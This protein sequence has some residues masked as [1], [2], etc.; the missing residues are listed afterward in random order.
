MGESPYQRSC[1]SLISPLSGRLL[2]ALVIVLNQQL[3]TE[4]HITPAASRAKRSWT[5]RRRFVVAFT[6]AATPFGVSGCQAVFSAWGLI[7]FNP[8][9]SAGVYQT[10]AI[11]R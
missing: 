1:A 5:S 8:Q 10:S 9:F 11:G 6:K 4:K 2:I 3:F 7:D